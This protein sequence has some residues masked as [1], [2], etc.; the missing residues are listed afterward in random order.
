[1]LA[2]GRHLD[3]IELVREVLLDEPADEDAQEVHVR[4]LEQLHGRAGAGEKLA[5]AEREELARF[6][7]RERLYALR[8]AMRVLVEERRPEL[9]APLSASVRDWME[10]L[11]K[12]Q[13]SES[14]DPFGLEPGDDEER[15]EALFG[16][17]WSMPG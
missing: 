4:A 7:D 9:L 17:R 10:E 16:S 15:S 12:A 1:M 2:S 11:R 6:A 8:E 3:A 5:R 13:G 14:T